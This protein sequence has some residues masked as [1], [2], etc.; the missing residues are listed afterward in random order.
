MP[1]KGKRKD[2]PRKMDQV[3]PPLKTL[4]PATGHLQGYETD[5]SI[6][7][8]LQ[9]GHESNASLSTAACGPHDTTS[10]FEKRIASLLESLFELGGLGNCSSKLREVAETLP[11]W[12]IILPITPT[13]NNISTNTDPQPT[14]PSTHIC[15]GS[16]LNQP[17]PQETQHRVHSPPAPKN[18]KASNSRGKDKGKAPGGVGTNPNPPKKSPLYAPPPTPFPP[19]REPAV[20]FH[21]APTKYKAGLMSCWIEENSKGARILGIRW[22]LQEGRRVAKLVSSL[23]IYVAEGIDITQWPRISFY[24]SAFWVRIV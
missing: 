13:R 1:A 17:D 11:D 3:T 19:Y 16:D 6:T 4:L 18:A 14:P 22:L 20:I 24:G 12:Q 9:D 21:A 5:T 8:P 7:A 23:I 15:G 10:T 2:N